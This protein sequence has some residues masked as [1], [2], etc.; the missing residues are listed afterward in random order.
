M[1]LAFPPE[2]PILLT[3]PFP[4]PQ[5]FVAPSPQS[6]VMNGAGLYDCSFAAANATCR[7]KTQR[8]LPE[9]R[10]PPNQR[11]RLRFINEGA[12][13]AL[14]FLPSIQRRRAD[15]ARLV[16][17]ALQFVSVDEH[18]LTVVG[19]SSPLGAQWHV[20]LTVLPWLAAEADFT[21]TMPLPVHRIPI[22]RSRSRSTLCAR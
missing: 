2:R 9:L 17:T 13:R 14:L 4:S 11:V 8:D 10:F 18:E 19:A 3:L 21:P 7:Q 15:H 12:H 22:V 5:S 1:R 16:K 6:N 20:E